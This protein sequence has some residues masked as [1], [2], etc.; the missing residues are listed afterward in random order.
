MISIHTHALNRP[1][2]TAA[3]APVTGAPT[4]HPSLCIE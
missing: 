4:L 3:P 2:L 1:Y